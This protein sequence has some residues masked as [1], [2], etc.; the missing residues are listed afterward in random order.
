[1][2]IALRTMKPYIHNKNSTLQ[3]GKGSKCTLRV[4]FCFVICTVCLVTVHCTALQPIALPVTYA[5]STPYSFTK[6]ASK[7]RLEPCNKG[8]P[9]Q[10]KVICLSE[11]YQILRLTVS[12]A[13]IN[14]L[15]GSFIHLCT[16]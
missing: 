4:Q 5:D 8:Q 7:L 3:F 16:F 14:R 9:S 12:D 10:L 1:M 6:I 15:S 13:N 11:S 2:K